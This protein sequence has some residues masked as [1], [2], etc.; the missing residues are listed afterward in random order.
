MAVMVVW[1]LA[2]VVRRQ[3]GLSSVYK[4]Y[5]NGSKDSLRST[6]G[7]WMAVRIV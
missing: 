4:M 5:L 7:S 1:G 2:E 6:R 3:Q